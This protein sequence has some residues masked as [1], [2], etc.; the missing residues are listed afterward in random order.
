VPFGG[1]KTTNMER[2]GAQNDKGALKEEMGVN[3][4]IEGGG[5]SQ[6]FE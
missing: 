6:W 1:G 2:E 3:H 5:K 4:E